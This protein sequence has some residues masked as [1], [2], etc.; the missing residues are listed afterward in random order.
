MTSGYEIH[1]K[2]GVARLGNSPNEFYLTPETIGGL[3]IECD[4]SGN[5]NQENESV[6][7]VTEFKDSVGRIKRQAQ[8]FRIFDHSGDCTT[9]VKLSDDNIDKIVW[10]VHIA[11]KKPIWYTFSELQ[12]NLEFG[13]EN[14]YENQH[15]PKNNPKVNKEKKRQK[16]IID[17]GPRSIDTPGDIV[18]FSR[19]NAPEHYKH[20]SFPP[21]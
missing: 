13:E 15:I 20:F 1:P 21:V 8:K 10:T 19:Y 11:N 3:P 14:S 7:F 5:P 18:E 16:L 12:G 9:E 17:P 4:E 6:K 2:I